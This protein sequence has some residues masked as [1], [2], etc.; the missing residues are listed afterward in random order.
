VKNNLDL[1]DLPMLLYID[2]K[3]TLVDSHS[4]S[5]ANRYDEHEGTMIS[6]VMDVFRQRNYL[7]CKIHPFPS[8]QETKKKT[9]IILAIAMR[10]EMRIDSLEFTFSDRATRTF[11]KEEEEDEDEQL[12]LDRH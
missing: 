11:L 7:E 3:I 10:E 8:V 6:R 5:E 4:S 12:K 9:C 2:K 1:I